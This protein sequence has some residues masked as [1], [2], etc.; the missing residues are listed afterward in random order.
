[1]NTLDPEKITELCAELIRWVE[2]CKEME[3]ICKTASPDMK[4]HYSMVYKDY[5]WRVQNRTG[6]LWYYVSG[7]DDMNPFAQQPQPL[8]S[9]D[10]D[11]K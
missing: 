8:P 4:E 9:L 2:K 3:E 1:M 6:K 11:T 7:C 10:K 5:Q